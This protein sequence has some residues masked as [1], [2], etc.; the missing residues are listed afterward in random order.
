MTDSR[1]ASPR[2]RGD[3]TVSTK[4]GQDQAMDGLKAAGRDRQGEAANK[5]CN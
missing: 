4:P 2:N 1:N 3:I 5:L